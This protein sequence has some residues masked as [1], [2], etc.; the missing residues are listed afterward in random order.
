MEIK[1]PADRSEKKLIKCP[2]CEKSGKVSVL[3]ELKGNVIEVLRFHSGSTQ[4]I[5]DNF[6]II[7]G[8]CK[9]KVFIKLKA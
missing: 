5:A 6:I 7:C 8:V 2:D 4:I 1:K 9:H 3:A